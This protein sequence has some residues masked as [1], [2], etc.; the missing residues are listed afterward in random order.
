MTPNRTG[1][2]PRTTGVGLPRARAL[3]LG[4][5]AA[6]AAR[7][8][9]VRLSVGPRRRHWAAQAGLG[10]LRLVAL[11]DS[12][13][14]GIGASVP[15]TS[16]LGVY[17]LALEN[18]T[19][20]RVRLDNRSGYGARIADV[21]ADQLPVPPDAERV[22]VCIGANDAGRTD[23]ETFAARFRA[24]C[25]QL[26]DGALVGDV[27]VFRWGSRVPAAA[28]LAA[29]VREVLAEF[30]GLALAQVE[31]HTRPRWMLADLSGDFFHP[32]DRGHADIAAAFIE[33]D[34]RLGP[35]VRDRA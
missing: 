28:E 11:G 33:A 15:A 21:L 8:L 10:D 30:P 34:P 17:R 20:R 19:G 22:T 35:A 25:R 4:S 23:P 16:W 29:V 32:N 2:R 18:Q 31:R 7:A 14:Q 27:P 5:L 6:F 3:A 1:A 24:L 12:L 26:P 9:Q 13:T